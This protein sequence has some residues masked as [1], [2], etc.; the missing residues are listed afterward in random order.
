MKESER[1]EA[2]DSY[3][4]KYGKS[5]RESGEH[6]KLASELKCHPLASYP[7]GDLTKQTNEKLPGFASHLKRKLEELHEARNLCRST[8]NSRIREIAENDSLV[9]STNHFVSIMYSM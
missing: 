4:E 6:R 9:I 7:I 1:I 8:A 2:Y 3:H 5:F